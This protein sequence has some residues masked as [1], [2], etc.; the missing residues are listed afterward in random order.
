VDH[1]AGPNLM[2][3]V[4]SLNSATPCLTSLT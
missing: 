3:W 1:L 4:E 2:G